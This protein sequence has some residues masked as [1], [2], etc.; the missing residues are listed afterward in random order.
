ALPGVRRLAQQ[1]HVSISTAVS[2]CRELEQRRLVEARPRSGFFVCP[3]AIQLET[4]RPR[5][6]K[7]RPR[8]ATGQDQLLQLV[9]AAGDRSIV[10]LGA[11]VPDADYLP[12]SAIEQ[13]IRTVWREQRRRCMGYEFPPGAP[14]LRVQ[15][16][17]RLAAM[18]CRVSPEQVLV[19]NSCHESLIIALRMLTSPGDVVVLESPT[20]YG[21]L[22]VAEALGLK[23][24]EVPSDPTAGISLEALREALQRWPVKACVV[25]A[26]FSNPLGVCLSDD[27]KQALLQLLT[28]HQVPLVEDDIYGDLPFAGPRPRPIKSW[29]TQGLVYYCSSS[30]KTVAAGLRVGW[31]VP[32]RDERRAS[33]L[34][35]IN[36]VSVATASQ[37][38]LAK[39]LERGR[40]EREMR[41]VSALHARS[42]AHMAERV[43]QLFPPGTRLSRPSGGFVLW[44]ELPGATDTSELLPDALQAGVS[45]A[46]GK[47]FSASGKYANCLRLNCAVRWDARVERALLTLVRLIDDGASQSRP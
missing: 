43:S 2:A 15:I 17:R 45:F 46:P 24:V 18:Q 31:L 39:Y 47:L 9:H 21:L 40:F 27:R 7:G 5:V 37:L 41:Q 13:A 35:F 1:H 29:D 4:P 6:S 16:A 38:A 11:A 8:A 12:A 22:Q 14:E 32:G 28:E 26:N 3:P 44:V 33:Y 20:Y 36:S 30:S 10:N 23:V 34:Q 42:V 25:V 19:T